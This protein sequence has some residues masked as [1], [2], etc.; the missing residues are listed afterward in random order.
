[1][2]GIAEFGSAIT[3]QADA[4]NDYYYRWKKADNVLVDVETVD[5]LIDSKLW[6]QPRSIEALFTRKMGAARIV[7]AAS[8]QLVQVKELIC[9]NTDWPIELSVDQSESDLYVSWLWQSLE[10]L[11]LARMAQSKDLA[12]LVV[13]ELMLTSCLTCMDMA[14]LSWYS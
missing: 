8:Q 5:M 6:L 9:G 1:M 2:D 12:H 4:S 3:D 14:K 7:Y 13:V 10:L 11:H